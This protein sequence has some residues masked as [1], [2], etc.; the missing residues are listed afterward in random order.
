LVSGL[1][2]GSTVVLYDGSPFLPNNNVLFDMTDKHRVSIFG[3]SP[4]WLQTCEERQMCPRASHDLG[5]LRT[6][7]TT[8]APLSPLHYDY[9]YNNIK[10]DVQLASIT[11]GTDII[12][13][14]AGAVADVPVYRG[15]LQARNLGMAISSWDECGSDIFDRSGELVCTKPFPSMPIYFGNDPDG[16]KYKKA[17]FNKYEGIWAHGDFLTIDSVTEGLV[18]HGR[19]DGTLNPGGVRFGSAEI[20]TVMDTFTAI[21]DTLCVGQKIKD[22]ERVILFLKMAEGEKFTDAL[23]KE[24]KMTIRSKLSA[25]HVPS[26]ILE[27]SD[28]PYTINGKKVEVAVKK[29]ISGEKVG[30]SGALR[31]P[32]CLDLY[33]N[34]TEIM[35]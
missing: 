34:I 16:Q 10:Q 20:Y 7:L 35:L 19:S 29:I 13:C 11:G 15:Q 27:T 1:A 9:V 25:R 6:I 2:A 21:V 24:I 23:K 14:F 18:M 12:S 22:D 33:K 32:E 26:V 4:K 3:T 28:I 5:S 31:N 8:G 17:Y 30:T